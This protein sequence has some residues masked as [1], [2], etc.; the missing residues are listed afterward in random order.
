MNLSTPKG[1]RDFLPQDMIV[2]NKITSV[3]KEVF[4]LYGFSPM[5]TP[6]METLEVL[7][8]K[9][10]A[11]EG[12]D[13]LK[14]LFKLTDQGKRN[15]GMKFDLTVPFSRVVGMNPNI[16]MPFKRYQMQN[17]YRDGP[18]TTNRYREFLQCDMDV[19]GVKSVKADAEILAATQE[20]FKRMKLQTEIRVNTRVLLNDLL[21]WLKV[22][23]NKK[24]SV[25]IAID[26]LDKVGEIEVQKELL[27]KGISESTAK[28][29][30][31][32]INVKGTNNEKICALEKE[33]G[34]S[35]GIKEIKELMNYCNEFDVS[36]VFCPSLVRG[37][38]Y[39]T[40]PIFEATMTNGSIKGSVAG[41]G[42]YDKM[43]GKYL[44]TEKEYPAT[45]ISFGIERIF[46]AYK[47]REKNTPKTTT[48]LYIIFVGVEELPLI[49]EL[50]KAGIKT[51]F[52]IDNKSISKALDYANKN[53]IPFVAIIGERELK[54]KE[55]KLK[56]M[57][58]GKEKTI[59]F[60]ETQK[61]KEMII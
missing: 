47:M 38:A 24:E 46:D 40:G 43:I 48:D 22:T 20:A 25:L 61:L 10:A 28:K 54:T 49:E 60:N 4:E 12:S 15:L 42:R 17:V 2:R 41:G 23:E 18:V 32:L 1:T 58:T 13:A 21:D 9:F 7:T 30:M 37:L 6:A 3:L 56:N 51:D 19:V 57:K 55:F 53:A 27:G 36:I 14:E 33:L 29:M 44:E 59:K 34:E 35:E 26:K 50:R 8:A 39:Y 31:Q 11:G 5:E 16:K 52:N 45:G